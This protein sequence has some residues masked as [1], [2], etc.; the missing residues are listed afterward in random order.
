MSTTPRLLLAVGA[1]LLVVSQA[2]IAAQAVPPCGRC[3]AIAVLPD[4]V[5]LLPADLTG[6]EILV[7][8]SPS[9]AVTPASLLATVA[10]RGGTPGVLLE[11]PADLP[12]LDA[13]ELR[14]VVISVRTV[15]SDL[16]LLA[17]DL[18]RRLTEARARVP[19][20]VRLGVASPSAVL[21]DLLGRDVGSYVDFV[22]SE[23]DPQAGVGWWRDAGE[24]SDPVASVQPH[25]PYTGRSLWRIPERATRFPETIADLAAAARVLPAGLVPSEGVTI[26]CGGTRAQVWFDPARL[27]HVALVDK[28]SPAQLR[29]MP[30]NAAPE[31]STLTTGAMLV[32]I[33]ET[34]RER[35]AEGVNVSAPRPLTI[36]EIIARHQAATARQS[37]AIRARISTGHLSLTFEAPGF[38]APLAITS[39]IVMFAA[40]GVE[41]IEQQDIRVNGL[42]LDDGAGP[43]LPLIEP[44]RV[45]S[46]PLAIELT[47]VYRYSLAGT[48]T[49]RGIQC[50]AVRFEPAVGGRT[51]FRGVAWIATDDFGLVKVAATQLGLR[52][53]IVS[54][55]QVDDFTRLDGRWLLHQSRLNQIYEGA[56]HR[57]P[58]ERVI[59]VERTEINP[60][61]FDSR[62]AA[63]LASPHVMV[64]DTPQGYRYIRRE[65][66]RRSESAAPTEPALEGPAQH[67]RTMAFGMIVD[68]NISH[69]LPFAGLS[70]VD[71]DLFGT[72]TQFNG[73][74]G[75]TFGQL[76]FAIP[77]VAGS[78]W[79]I[80]GR[81][82]AIASS[83]NDRSFDAG[84]ERYDE[85][86]RQRPAQASVSVLRP[87]TPRVT[88][89]VAYELDYTAYARAETTASQ[90]VAPTSQT[91]H[92][93]RF[94]I[95]G[96]RHGWTASAWW[97]PAVRQRW[98]PWGPPAGDHYSAEHRDFQRFG[99]SLARSAFV[100][101]SVVVRG[102][103][104]WMDGHDLDR[105]SRYAFGA[106][107]NRLHG[108]PSA[109]I[110][111]DRGAIGR[112]AIAWSAAPR[113]RIDGFADFAFVHDPGFGSGLKPFTGLGMAV[114]TPAPLG[115][116]LAAEW[117]FGLQGRRSDGRRGTHVLRVS[118][119]KIF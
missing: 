15:P 68:P 62:R 78:R 89:K 59:T 40:R 113:L 19:A 72:G 94:A 9:D 86:I 55:D 23:T 109:L 17:F 45:A 28:C 51:L 93:A 21:Q 8:I 116:L 105:F 112:G 50:Y 69:P 7:R 103:A 24:L 63:A 36:Q 108:Y 84:I 22:V 67:V 20:G 32:E 5:P 44:E 26:D 47:D 43:R 90:F 52:G 6:L 71:F 61:D 74:I 76:A 81:A 12:L 57:T 41:E 115:T 87:L 48:E 114:E 1:S 66:G 25:G 49:V 30:A 38:V 102:E 80:A 13:P 42:A 34:S 97:A 31:V 101:P 91:I 16:T 100:T 54:S 65:P 99:A 92:A 29:I 60:P 77:S 4:Q 64:R 2:R 98:T 18:K 106:F 85:N 88:L 118:A 37:A 107:D 79:Q 110:R 14:T 33:A 83:F 75:G 10:Q 117:G 46:A 35:F 95:E 82:F 3:L 70:Y 111:Y 56:A 119:Y 96:Q 11:D 53:P 73:F 27:T 58:I 39:R 104:A